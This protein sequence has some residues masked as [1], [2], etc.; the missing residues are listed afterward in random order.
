MTTHEGFTP[1]EEWGKWDVEEVG[2]TWPARYAVH[3]CS[4]LTF[5]FDGEEGI[6]VDNPADARL[7]ADAPRLYAELQKVEAALDRLADAEDAYR[8]GG[9]D[10]AMEID[11]ALR[12]ARAALTGDD[13]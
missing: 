8:L 13:A 3:G 1:I 10:G 6:Y 2:A 4:P 12:Q 11:S 7:I 5:G 9:E